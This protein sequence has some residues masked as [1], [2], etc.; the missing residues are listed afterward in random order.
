MAEPDDHGSGQP[1]ESRHGEQA[2]R[3]QHVRPRPEVQG[4]GHLRLLQRADVRL[5]R[6]EALEI[7]TIATEK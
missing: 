5:V 1:D 2:R 4:Q 6:V 7:R 3:R